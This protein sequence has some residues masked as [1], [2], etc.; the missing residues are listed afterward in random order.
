LSSELDDP[1]NLKAE[2]GQLRAQQQQQLQGLDELRRSL[3]Q[4]DRLLD[5]LRIQQFELEIRNRALREAQEQLE[6]TRETYVD[7]FDLAPVAYL[8][9]EADGRIVEANLAAA[10]LLGH[11][12]ALLPGRRFQTLVGMVDPFTFQTVLR[13]ATERR[14]ELR[15]EIS[16]R[17]VNQ[18]TLTVDVVV[19]PTSTRLHEAGRVRVCLHDV[20]SRAL[21]EQ[22]LR[23]LS[24]AGSRLTRIQLGSDRILE[25]IAAA[26]C[27]GAVEGCWVE[28][29]DEEASAWRSE[30]SRRRMNGAALKNLRLQIAPTIQE[31]RAGATTVVGGWNASLETLSGW[32]AMRTWVS[33]ALAVRGSVVGS[34]TLFLSF[35]LDSEASARSLTEEFARRVTMVLESSVLYRKAEEATRSRDEIMT[36]L[37]HD[38]SNT[39]FSFRLHAQ[40]GLARGGKQAQRALAAVAR[41]SQRLL[42]LVKTVL[43]VAGMEEGRIKVQRQRGNLAQVLESACLLQQLDADERKLEIARDWP[44]DL[45]FDFDQERLLQVL[46]NLVNNAVKFTPAG[47][48]VQV[49]A[50]RENGQVRVWV[51]DSGNGLGPEELERVFERGWQADPKGGGKGLGLY[52][53]RRIVEAHGGTMWVES[54]LGR[55]ATF[56]AVLPAE[57]VVEAAQDGAVSASP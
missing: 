15:S 34:V 49:G 27:S 3:V 18:E 33:T 35:L 1:A 7:L 23:F 53:S 10:R 19:L 46:F 47:G 57:Q 32:A 6:A 26:G 20:T 12:R 37:A 30:P 16:F 5:E 21:A 51:H 2:L 8:T 38:L 48:R 42:G 55:G 13:T 24:E 39:L 29:G 43:D 36:V 54:T 45:S 17:T 41:G 25:E 4:T 11:D 40:R 28:F 50:D 56:F 52:I 31:A 44:E 9:V 22:S 14:G